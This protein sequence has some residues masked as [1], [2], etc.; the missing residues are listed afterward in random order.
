[1]DDARHPFTPRA[2]T[3]WR[4]VLCAALLPALLTPLVGH[5]QEI[6]KSV[7]DSGHVIYSD[8]GN[9]KTAPKTSI[10]VE[11]PDTANA[12]RL[13]KEQQLLDA[14]EKQRKSQQA[15]D[16]KGKAQQEAKARQ[17][18]QRCQSAKDRYYSMK[19]A[20]RL[21]SRDADG[22]RVYYSDEDADKR[23]EEARRTMQTACAD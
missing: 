14:D 11:P 21:F 13:A 18:Q 17:R 16:D 20:T 7:D 10:H 2:R 6:Y 19:D 12:A 9:S 1:M 3:M 22:N 5:T 23:R 8:R 4:A 15:L